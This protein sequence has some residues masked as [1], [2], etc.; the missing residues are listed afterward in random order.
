MSVRT[1]R[2]NQST[3][4]RLMSIIKYSLGFTFASFGRQTG[5]TDERTNE[6]YSIFQKFAVTTESGEKRPTL[7][8]HYFPNEMTLL[9]LCVCTTFCWNSFYIVNKIWRPLLNFKIHTLVSSIKNSPPMY[10]K[11]IKMYVVFTVYSSTFQTPLCLL[12]NITVVFI[13]IF[14]D[15]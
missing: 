15:F 2:R 6:T 7:R 3:Y 12:H 4:T 5:R 1:E 14:D 11:W 10:Q 8:F 13:N 9:W